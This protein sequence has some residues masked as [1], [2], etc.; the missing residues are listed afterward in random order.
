MPSW[1]KV[2]TSGSNAAINDITLS[3]DATT[4]GS[5]FTLANTTGDL[6]ITNN[7]NDQD[8]IFQSDNG[9]GGTTAYITLDGSEGTVEIAKATNVDG[10]LTSTGDVVAFYSS[11]KRLKDNIEPIEDPLEKMDKIGGYTFIWNDKQST[12]E[13]HDIGVI[14]QE[15]QEVLPELVTERDNG[16][17]AVKYEKI[18]PLLIESIKELKQEVDDIKQKCDCLNK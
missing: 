9:S 11:D 5:N 13:G 14:A 18:V 16:Y 10:T 7:A 1:K 6:T 4:I 2:I 12:Y 8:V 15:I 17:L 3:G